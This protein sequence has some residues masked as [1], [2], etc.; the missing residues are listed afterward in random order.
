M[1]DNCL[2][3]DQPIALRIIYLDLLVGWKEGMVVI[4]HIFMFQITTQKMFLFMSTTRLISIK[5]GAFSYDI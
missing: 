4:M 2:F 5:M 3:L 1:H